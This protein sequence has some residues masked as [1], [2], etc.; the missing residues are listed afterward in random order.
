M[1]YSSNKLATTPVPT[2]TLAIQ[3]ITE[4]EAWIT[5]SSYLQLPLAGPELD[6]QHSG[7]GA[8]S[9]GPRVTKSFKP[10]L[11]ES[12]AATILVN[13]CDR[14]TEQMNLA[15]CQTQK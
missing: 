7:G 1:T 5:T 11:H 8:S 9:Q 4:P 3:T 13:V 2:W 10:S 12:A 14:S 6:S 15:G